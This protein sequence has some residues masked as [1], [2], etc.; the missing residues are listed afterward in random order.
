MRKSDL[1]ES[2]AT[3]L[4]HYFLGPG[5]IAGT[6]QSVH[7]WVIR[8]T[9][10]VRLMHSGRNWREAFRK[11]G[12]KLPVRPQFSPQKNRV[13]EGDRCV[14]VACSSTFATRTANALNEYEPNRRGL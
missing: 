14:A 2:Q 8:N 3:D 4:A 6:D 7:Y 13:M 9:G 11:A 12:V 5:W 10:I 1:T